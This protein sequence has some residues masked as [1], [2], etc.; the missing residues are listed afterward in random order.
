[1]YRSKNVKQISGSMSILLVIMLVFFQRD[2]RAQGGA[3]F[4]A[5][6]LQGKDTLDI[7][8]GL[9][10][11]EPIRVS[12]VNKTPHKLQTIEVHFGN[13]QYPFTKKLYKVAKGQKLIVIDVPELLAID[14]RDIDSPRKREAEFSRMV[15]VCQLEGTAKY[16]SY[17]IP[18]KV[19]E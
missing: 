5:F 10:N 16:A 3:G 1:M 9:K 11:H 12:W 13:G 17:T 6:F 14:T 7:R 8:D 15:V 18:F 4:S 19:R 2:A